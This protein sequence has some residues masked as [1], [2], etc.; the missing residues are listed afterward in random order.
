MSDFFVTVA[1]EIEVGHSD[2]TCGYSNHG[3][4]LRVEVT[5]QGRYETAKGSSADHVDLGA[6]LDATLFEVKGKPLDVIA[7][8]QPTP[9]GLALWLI[10]RMLP[11]FPKIV[12]VKVWLDPQVSFSVK[13]EPR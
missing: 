7:P 1:R 8:A 10:E 11:R 2:P 6:A 13:R 9:E 5:V 12:E 3:H 4:R